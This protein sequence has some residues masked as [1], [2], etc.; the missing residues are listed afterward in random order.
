MSKGKAHLEVAT[1]AV[2]KNRCVNC[3]KGSERFV[4]QID[5][6]LSPYKL[7]H[8]VIMAHPPDIHP[9]GYKQTIFGC[10]QSIRSI[11]PWAK[12]VLKFYIIFKI[13]R[14]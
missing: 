9:I 4:S 3:E 14:L 2:G 1:V 13:G 5:D 7:H 11:N 8:I 12:C 6:T 10:M